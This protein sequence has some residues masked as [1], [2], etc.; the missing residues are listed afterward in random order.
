MKGNMTILEVAYRIATQHSL[1]G[2]CEPFQEFKRYLD[3][4]PEN[5]KLEEKYWSRYSVWLPVFVLSLFAVLVLVVLAPDAGAHPIL[6]RV[7]YIA[8]MLMAWVII[9]SSLIMTIWNHTK[10][11]RYGP[12]RRHEELLEKLEA[13]KSVFSKVTAIQFLW[14]DSTESIRETYIRYADMVSAGTA[15]YS[16]SWYR[17]PK[18]EVTVA[19]MNKVG[20]HFGLYFEQPVAK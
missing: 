7:V 16:D 18:P 4:K 14:G 9:P 3:M 5:E 12:V 13:F 17:G 8:V 10:S 19:D 11:R 20:R 2:E 15:N 6:N 1:E